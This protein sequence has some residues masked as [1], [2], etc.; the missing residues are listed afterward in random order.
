MSTPFPGI[1]P[2]LHD[3]SE[4]AE[5]VRWES[6]VHDALS[7]MR[8]GTVELTPGS[9]GAGAEVV[10]V[11][12]APGVAAG[13]ALVLTAPAGFS[14]GLDFVVSAADNQIS[15]SFRNRSGAPIDPGTSTW[16]YL[17]VRT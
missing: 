7:R 12:A 4:A 14:A 1:P 11:V 13:M 5:R 10:A 8:V 2:K 16:S 9:I 15:V 3:L 6:A 17:G